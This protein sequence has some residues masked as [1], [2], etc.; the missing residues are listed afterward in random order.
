MLNFVNLHCH[1][2]KSLL[3]GASHVGEMVAAAKKAGQ[4]AFA[5]TDH[6]N[7][8]A[9]PELEHEAKKQ[10]VKP[11]YGIEAY[12]A[13]IGYLEDGQRYTRFVKHRYQY[14]DGGDGDL[15]A[16][17]YTHLTL[18]AKN[19]DGVRS[20]I[21]ISSRAFLEGFYSKPRADLDLLREENEG[22]N[23]IVLTGCPSSELNT[24]LHLNQI[25]EA[26]E[27]MNTLIDIFGHENVFVEIMAHQFDEGHEVERMNQDGL[28]GIAETFHLPLV[29]TNDSHY[30]TVDDALT[31]E[32]CIA[33][34][35]RSKMTD[36]PKKDGGTR[37]TF[38][39][40]GYHVRSG[41]EMLAALISDGFSEDVARSA[42][43][44]SVLI[45]EMTD[46]HLPKAKGNELWPHVSV[47]AEFEQ[48]HA[49]YL[50][51]LGCER[52][53]EIYH[54]P[55]LSREIDRLKYEIG[56]IGPK[57]YADYFLFTAE[58]VDWAR[59]QNI[60]IGPGRGSAGGALISYALGITYLDPL[61]YDLPFERFL[62]PERES[63]PDIDLDVESARREEVFQHLKDTYGD[64]NVARIG[65]FSIIKPKTAIKDAARL[66]NLPFTYSNY[67]ADVIPDIVKDEDTVD[68][69]LPALSAANKKWKGEPQPF[70]TLIDA[71]RKLCGVTRQTGTHAC[72]AEGTLISTPGGFIPIEKIQVG[73]E[74][75]THT[76]N[77]YPV[78]R[79]WDE[80]VQPVKTIQTESSLPLRITEDHPVLARTAEKNNHLLKLHDDISWVPVSDLTTHV[81]Y[82]PIPPV[83]DSK[84]T[85]EWEKL[86]E[87]YDPA[88]AVEVSKQAA[89]AIHAFLN[90]ATKKFHGTSPHTGSFSFRVETMEELLGLSMIAHAGGYAV[91]T[92]PSVKGICIGSD[93]NKVDSWSPL[94]GNEDSGEAHVYNLTVEH[95]NSY[96]ANG[97]A[98][99][100]CG[101]IFSSQPITNFAPIH[102]PKTSSPITT[103]WEYKPLE[104]TGF[105][106]EDI[107]GLESLSLIKEAK[108]L[109][110]SVPDYV[111]LVKGGVDD[112]KT[113]QLLRSGNLVGVFQADGGIGG[114][115]QSI[116]AQ[117]IHDLANANGLFRPGPLGMGTPDHFAKRKAGVEKPKDVEIE[118]EA[119]RAKHPGPITQYTM[120]DN[121]KDIPPYQ[122]YYIHHEL[123]D[124]LKPILD[125]TYGLCVAGDTKIWDADRNELV[126]IDS[127]KKKVK[128]GF[129]T[130]A[131]GEDG[132]VHARKVTAWKKTG[133]KK[134]LE[135]TTKNGLTIRVTKGH[136]MLTT[137]GWKKAGELTNADVLL[138]PSR[139]EQK[140]FSQGFNRVRPY[141]LRYVRI[142]WLCED[143]GVETLDE[144]LY[145]IG[146]P[147]RK[148]SRKFPNLIR[149]DETLETYLANHATKNKAFANLRL[150]PIATIVPHKKEPVYDITVEGDH[151]FLANGLIAHNCLM[152]EQIMQITQVLAGYTPGAADIFRRAIGKKEKKVLDSQYEP[153]SA[154][155]FK[156]GYSQEAVDAVWQVIVPFAGYSFNKSHM[157]G[158]GMLM[159]VTAY[160]KAHH[161]E[162]FYAA[163]L[164]VYRDNKD[165]NTEVLNEMKRVGLNVKPPDMLIS[166][167]ATLVKGSTVY[168][169]FNQ[170]KGISTSGGRK[171]AELPRTW[172]EFISAC[173][174]QLKRFIPSLIS[175]GAFDSQGYSRTH[176][177]NHQV[178][179]PPD[180]GVDSF[181]DK[182]NW[183]AELLGV[184]ISGG[185]LDNVRE[186]VSSLATMKTHDRW[187]HYEHLEEVPTN[188]TVRV[189][190]IVTKKTGKKKAK[191]GREYSRVSLEMVDQKEVTI[192]GFGRMTDVLAQVKVGDFLSVIGRKASDAI[193][194]NS[195]HEETF[196]ESGQI[197]QDFFAPLEKSRELWT[198]SRSTQ[199]VPG[200]IMRLHLY[201]HDAVQGILE[202][203]RKAKMTEKNVTSWLKEVEQITELPYVPTFADTLTHYHYNVQSTIIQPLVAPF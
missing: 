92:Y 3:D 146:S 174:Q 100:N 83:D 19:E 111:T 184:S 66:Y 160:I 171:I 75:L 79:V 16:G 17:S 144:A 161:P 73:D 59:S 198:T 138:Q 65:T 118:W 178:P 18:L 143:M 88:M 34:N 102:K 76:G 25:A 13:P 183:E 156:N 104:A 135:I 20:L 129:R 33:A 124:A 7:L 133:V 119:W 106:K 194:A 61:K 107:L 71:A 24:R 50:F 159:Y 26:H 67:L 123:E 121:P 44:Q 155:M 122:H 127:I 56:V 70:D 166:S 165:K 97:I 154:G 131:V 85:E 27:Y 169:G 157:Y 172:N 151:N 21:R 197:V 80:G 53:A 190:G 41:E 167:E 195:A 201:S 49:A 113:Y 116:N 117:S 46:G 40:F 149:V 99:H 55:L 95:D 203:H 150:A 103:Q 179:C 47:P 1:T 137:D 158:Y 170:I 191:S 128:Q 132:H 162:A 42:L 181:M 109:D 77:V 141:N 98:V 136:R 189:A 89:P 105:I 147:Q 64:E 188:A 6:G 23:L 12:M 81:L 43:E 37:M 164:N 63:P 39:G 193:F 101:T 176:L 134:T 72:V 185:K 4:G 11:I 84:G 74:V 163:A 125:P 152:Q 93:F 30:A 187:E 28:L 69:F 192:L 173:P 14:G 87:N 114:V 60:Y 110:P 168:L 199:Y 86:G 2:D 115:L 182:L 202:K 36:V 51:Q 15:T 9:W 48:D 177:L 96:V 196:N 45:A 180:H 52:L 32:L 145:A 90:G 10:G 94:R 68:T 148:V 108:R 35:S 22:K 153:F 175:V 31:Q 57:G 38:D 142:D 8:Y 82:S 200:K 54:R 120:S 62:N 130:L 58:L 78:R 29:A 140:V 186:Y 112:E 5:V 91:D 126:R 139:L